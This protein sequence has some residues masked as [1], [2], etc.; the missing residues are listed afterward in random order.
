MKLKANVKYIDGDGNPMEEFG[1]SVIESD[2]YMTLK[3]GVGNVLKSI[4]HTYIKEINW[5]LD[6]EEEL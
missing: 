4:P 2:K 3:G 1:V 6:E 5:F